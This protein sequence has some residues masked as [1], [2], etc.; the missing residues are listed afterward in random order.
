MKRS[1]SLWG[2]IYLS[3]DFGSI[4]R[5]LDACSLV[6]RCGRLLSG[7]LTLMVKSSPLK[8]AG[9]NFV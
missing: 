8:N 5:K 3:N 6:K 9:L 4:P 1:S 7:V 2:R